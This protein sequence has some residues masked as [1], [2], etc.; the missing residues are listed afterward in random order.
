MAELL[1]L[2][3]AETKREIAGFL[4]DTFKNSVTARKNQIEDKYA[5]WQRNYAAEPVEKIKT[6]PFYRA[7][8]FMPRLIAMH[9]DIL[10]ARIL[11]VMFSTRP[12]WIL[13]HPAILALDHDLT[14][15]LQEWIN[16]ISDTQIEL[17]PVMDSLIRRAI[18]DGT[19]IAKT[20][21]FSDETYAGAVAPDNADGWTSNAVTEEGVEIKAVPFEDF[22][23]YP[24]TAN[25]L[26]EVQVKFHRIRMTK[27]DVN[28]R[29]GRWSKEGIDVLLNNPADSTSEAARQAR[30][31]DSGI[32]L[33]KDVDFPYHVIEAWFCYR[34]P[35]GKTY[36]L[37]AVFNPFIQGED[38]LL[39]LYFN[40]SSKGL[41][42]FT[43]FRPGPREDL[44]Y[45]Y[46][47]PEVLEQF[48]EEQAQ[49]HNARRDA[50]VIQNVP[51]W[52][53]RRYAETP[54]PSSEW[55][56]GC[57]MTLDNMEDLMPLQFNVTY[58]SM[59]PEEQFVMELAERSLGIS[60]AQQA[61]G[62]GQ[63]GKRGTYNTGG[64]LALLTEGNRRLDIYI[65]RLRYPC[66]QVARRIYHNYRDNVDEKTLDVF[67]KK[68]DSIRKILRSDLPMAANGI[69][70][71]LACSD[72]GI[73]R[74]VDRQNMLLLANTLGGYYRQI[75]EAVATV[76][77]IPDGH[78]AKE[79]LLFVLD[80][81]KDMVR[82]ILFTFDVPDRD[83]LVPDL[84]AIL[85]G[86]A[87]S[88]A[89]GEPGG[90]AP[91]EPAPTREGL[92]SLLGELNK[93][94]AASPQMAGVGR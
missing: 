41:D 39:R 31:Q 84:R 49:I 61:F 54:D 64:T 82:R 63:Q 10:V 25:N 44:F 21:W 11:N 20:I 68:A 91:A 22:W 52:K 86:R 16:Y 89:E 51:G 87:K 65:K 90:T 36:R 3:N 15:V 71:D 28:A 1:D 37:A 50:S 32:Q 33:T 81:A 48:Q 60:A 93:A 94:T 70:F 75:W 13:K 92:Q 19:T 18:K 67:G 76:T 7:S 6:S 14:D 66:H 8:N 80:G 73:N 9:S 38:A 62:S 46:A 30:S 74:E 34:L 2:I 83:R 29:R 24:V 77:Q 72:A 26:S 53:K 40:P 56:P 78:P 59:L 57:T 35:N 79:A 55:Y 85:E 5:R 4:L 88:D 47:A 27:Y 12:F 23:P 69:F 43:D 45:G 58:N 42:P 17:F